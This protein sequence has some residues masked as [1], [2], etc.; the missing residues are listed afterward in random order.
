MERTEE[1][2]LRVL[3]SSVDRVNAFDLD[4]AVNKRPDPVVND[5]P[6]WRVEAYSC[7]FLPRVVLCWTLAYKARCTPGPSQTTPMPTIASAEWN[8]VKRHPDAR[9]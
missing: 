7:S 9:H 8:F 1:N 2:L 3:L 5:L 4:V 6:R